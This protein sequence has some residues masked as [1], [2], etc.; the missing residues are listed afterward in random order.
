M[1]DKEKIMGLKSLNEKKYE[2]IDLDHLMMYVM[3]KLYELGVD[4]SFE[5]AT[6]AA[7]KLFPKKFSLVGY[8]E[9]PDANR[10][11]HCLWR[12]AGHRQWLGGKSRQGFIITERSKLVIKKVE[13]MLKKGATGKKNAHAASQTRRKEAL[14]LEVASSIAYKKYKQGEGDNITEVELCF[15]LQGTLDSSRALLKENLDVLRSYAQT[16]EN[17]K[18]LNFLNWAES[19][20]KDFFR[21]K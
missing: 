7:S 6:V 20:F 18:I 15:L 10:T 21:K 11:G 17:E 9:Y 2:N 16:L 4:L 3:G 5:N 8:P 19:N 14:L 13:D 12:C 1:K